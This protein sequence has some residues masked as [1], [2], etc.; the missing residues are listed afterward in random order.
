M[1]FFAVLA[2]IFRKL[3]HSSD[4]RQGRKAADW[5]RHATSVFITSHIYIMAPCCDDMVPGAALTPCLHLLSI[6]AWTRRTIT[7]LTGTIAT[8]E[9]QTQFPFLQFSMK[10]SPGSREQPAEFRNF[11]RVPQLWIMTSILVAALFLLLRILLYS[12]SFPKVSM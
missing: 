11:C 12:S 2:R 6:P 8:L 3:R 5:V 4:W 9:C 1:Q 7:L 10:Q